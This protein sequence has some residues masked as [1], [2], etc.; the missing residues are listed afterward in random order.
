MLS[1]QFIVYGFVE[2]NQFKG[3]IAYVK[4]TFKLDLG[5]RPDFA[6]EWERILHK[7]VAELPTNGRVSRDKDGIMTYEFLIDLR[8]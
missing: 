3:K 7:R 2:R 8:K 5:L 6:Q 4:I 1:L